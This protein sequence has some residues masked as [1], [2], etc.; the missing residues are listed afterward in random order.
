VRT[1]LVVAVG[2]LVLLALVAAKLP[3]GWRAGGLGTIAGLAFGVA[4]ISIR[5]L[6]NLHS[7]KS[8][9]EDPAFYVMIA[10]GGGA[11]LLFATALQ[12]SKVT[13]AQSGM[14]LGQTVIPAIVG[15]L[16]LGDRPRDGF[17]PIAL[18]GFVCA[19]VGAVV[20]AR[21]EAREDAR[22]STAATAARQETEPPAVQRAASHA[23]L[24]E[25]ATDEPRRGT[26]RVR[27]TPE[28][29]SPPTAP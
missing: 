1:G 15:V 18:F 24:R 29:H 23:T 7:V 10:C 8:L 4:S 17:M 5:V 21:F 22:E 9:A 6:G 19:I 28:R 12:Q 16:V 3:T 14:V 11:F 26:A 2:V 25:R 27:G 20:L 13:V